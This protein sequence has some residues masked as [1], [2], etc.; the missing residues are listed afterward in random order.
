MFILRKVSNR[1]SNIPNLNKKERILVY[2]PV[3]YLRYWTATNLSQLRD[4]AAPSYFHFTN[5]CSCYHLIMP[6][7]FFTVLHF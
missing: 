4:L 1:R 3:F 2:Y 5:L 6:C 7:A